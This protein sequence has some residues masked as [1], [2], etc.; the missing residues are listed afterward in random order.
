MIIIVVTAHEPSES[1]QQLKL[2]PYY[3]DAVVQSSLGPKLNTM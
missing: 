3:L 2:K 1:I